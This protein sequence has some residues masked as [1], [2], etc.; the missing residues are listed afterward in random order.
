MIQREDIL[1]IEF[2]KKTEFTGCYQGIR[3]RLEKIEKKSEEKE[4]S[5]LQAVIWSEPFNYFSTPEEKKVK[6]VFSFSEE[7]IIEAIAWMNDKWKAEF[8]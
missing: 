7:G 8:K 2:L 3:Y 4:E 5:F 1:S 6:K